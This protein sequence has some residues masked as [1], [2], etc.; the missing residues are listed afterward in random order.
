MLR[1]QIAA[2]LTLYEA[3]STRLDGTGSLRV[4]LVQPMG[5]QLVLWRGSLPA[6]HSKWYLI[7]ADSSRAFRL[8]GFSEPDV[9]EFV[10]QVA[11][12]P[13]SRE[14]ADALGRTIARVLDP[15]GGAEIV[16]AADAATD[17]RTAALL[18]TWAGRRPQIWPGDTTLVFASGTLVRVTVLTRNTRAISMPWTAR[19]YTIVFAQDGR[20]IAW[21]AR[22]SEVFTVHST[23]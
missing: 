19:L 9:A 15:H 12:P 14:E 11:P 5:N 1:P 10:S 16:Y 6:D 7:A 20:L 13:R 2:D 17:E 23:L 4:E 8:G 3:A 18:R 22:N 21:S